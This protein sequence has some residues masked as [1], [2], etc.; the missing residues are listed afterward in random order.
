MI[1]A[2]L[3]VVG[4]A[5]GAPTRYLLDRSIQSRHET[6]MPWGTMT[7]NILGTL[8]LGLLTG[9]ASDHAV[10]H[11][12]TLLLGTG[13]CGALTTFGTFSFESLR[14][15]QT[16]ARTQAALNIVVAITAGLG[17]VSI[18]YALGAAL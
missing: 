13:M 16:G 5:F 17:A 12:I 2:L 10:P 18:G 4:A 14:L 9:L 8:I 7:V 15:Y 3:V 11:D 6:E 1:G